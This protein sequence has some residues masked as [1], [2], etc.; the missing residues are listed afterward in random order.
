MYVSSDAGERAE[1]HARGHEGESETAGGYDADLGL[2]TAVRE[3]PEDFYGGELRA[4]AARPRH[5]EASNVRST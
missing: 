1:R 2:S 5:A 4:D 3:E